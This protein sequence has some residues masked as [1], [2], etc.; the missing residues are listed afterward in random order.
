LWSIARFDL[1]LGE[2]EFLCMIPAALELLMRRLQVHDRK[3]VTG[4]AMVSAELWNEPFTA[5]HFLPELPE[6][7]IRREREEALANLPP[8]AEQFEAYKK[9]LFA[10]VP[11]KK[12]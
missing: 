11:K 4:G 1:R 5:A 7:R 3:Q 6:E 2:D 12:G 10:N 9:Q 8:T